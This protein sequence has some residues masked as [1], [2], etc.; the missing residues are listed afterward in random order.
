MSRRVPASGGRANLFGFGLN[1][2]MWEGELG[3]MH[4]ASVAELL[5]LARQRALTSVKGES[6]KDAGNVWAHILTE[7]H[8]VIR[9]RREAFLIKE[10][11]HARM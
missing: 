1:L 6:A 4:A 5:L 8:V 3:D 7:D 9:G 2:R 11:D 10:I